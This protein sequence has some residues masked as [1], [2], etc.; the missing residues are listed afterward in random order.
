MLRQIP[1]LRSLCS[2]RSEL[3]VAEA[4]VDDVAV[5]RAEAVVEAELEAE[6]VARGQALELEQ[7][8]LLRIVPA[9]QRELVADAAVLAAHVEGEAPEQ[10][11]ID[12]EV[13]PQIVVLDLGDEGGPL[14]RGP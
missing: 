12:A 4:R 9:R 10:V 6:I 2:L 7:D 13:G 14:D 3:D 8:L 1:A 5:D 11:D